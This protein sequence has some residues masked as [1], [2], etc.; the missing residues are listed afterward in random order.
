MNG[1]NGLRNAILEHE[2]QAANVKEN[3]QLYRGL[4]KG[5]MVFI[6][7]RGYP[8]KLAVDINV[9]DGMY[10]YCNLYQ[11]IAIIIGA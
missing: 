5:E 6:N 3:N 8:Y 7:G 11:S 1:L 10:I 2:R 9:I 4:I